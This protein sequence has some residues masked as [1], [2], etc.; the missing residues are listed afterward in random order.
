M[1]GLEAHQSVFEIT[2]RRYCRIPFLNLLC[3][4][5]AVIFHRPK[6]GDPCVY[7]PDF[8][9]HRPD[10]CIYSQFYLMKLGLPVTWDNPD[11]ALL[12]NGIEQNTF[13]LRVDT[14]YEV[15]ITVHN[16]SR[17]KQAPGTQVALRLVEFGAGAQVRT[18][19]A[20]LV[21]DVP[22]F[23]G[24]SRVSANWHTPATPGHFCLEVELFHPE[25]GNPSNNLGWNNTI[26][27]AAQSQVRVPIRVF[28]TALPYRTGGVEPESPLPSHVPPPELVQ[29]IVDSYRFHDAFGKRVNPDTMFA[30]RAPVWNARIEPDRFHFRENE[31]FHEVSLIVDTPDDPGLREVFNVSALQAGALIGGITA[32]I[33]T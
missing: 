4:I 24:T 29:I 19:I 12:L 17:E 33:T 32:T 6:V 8:I 9:V 23:P 2:D 3:K 20:N 14:D 18:P 30:P 15:V 5:F 7:I 21:A 31:V 16:A 13:D 28:N 11:V 10:P 26:V 25:D 1:D 27:R 22:P